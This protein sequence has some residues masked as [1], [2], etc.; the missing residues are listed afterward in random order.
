MT[1]ANRAVFAAFAAAGLLALL[2]AQRARAG[3][4][5][6]VT[7]Q[8][9]LNESGSPVN[10]TKTMVFRVTSQDGSVEYFNSGSTNV[11]VSG[12]LFSVEFS[13]VG[14]PWESI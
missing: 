9:T 12:G 11:V 7:Y 4:P 8:G 13:I 14:V 5:T 6:V 3:V 1:R 10:A 2:P